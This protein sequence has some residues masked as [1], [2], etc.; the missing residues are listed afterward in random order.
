M[1]F[2]QNVTDSTLWRDRVQYFKEHYASTIPLSIYQCI[3]EADTSI[4][5]ADMH[6]CNM[7]HVELK[8]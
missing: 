6:A 8:Y 5:S 4:P 7:H 1:R 2:E 3:L